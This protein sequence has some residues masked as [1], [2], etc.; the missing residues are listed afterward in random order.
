MQP[1]LALSILKISLIIIF[2]NFSTPS[3]NVIKLR[4]KLDNSPCL[5]IK[6][7]GAK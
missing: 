7:S 6:L 3:G 1:V 2:K 5:A 4:V